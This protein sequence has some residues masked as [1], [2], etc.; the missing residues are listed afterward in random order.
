MLERLGLKT[1]GQLLDVPRGQLRARFGTALPLRLD[2]A[3]GLEG[4]A[5]TS[6]AYDAVYRE[7]LDFAEPVAT[8]DGIQIAT[9]LLVETLASRLSAEGKAARGFIL[10][11]YDTQSE[12]TDVRLALA[13]PSAQAGH[14]IALF[15]G[16]FALLEGRFGREI[17]FDAATLL[18]SP[19]E[20]LAASQPHLPSAVNP[21][22]N[23]DG[24]DLFIDHLT[25][26]LGEDAVRSF[27]F[28]ESHIPEHA[29]ATISVLRKALPE[30]RPAPAARPLLIL[31]RPEEI[32]AIA[33][34]PDYPP[35]AF[36][37]RRAQHK[38]VK[39]E[40]PERIAPEWWRG[41]TGLAR[42]YYAVEDDKGRRFWLYREGAFGTGEDTPC[43]YMHGLLP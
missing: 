43:W 41:E 40:G 32:I 27:D 7:R 31:P 35:R 19:V 15:R 37:W 34:L 28:R 39:V 20:N 16:R 10:T 11:L 30:P 23:S 38:V 3:L 14:I 22:R 9:G 25:A 33:A 6:L 13:R 5:Q 8:V 21:A 29:A 12:S 42:D 36:T 18:A 2:Q 24:L 4:A 1:I 26:Q 17:A